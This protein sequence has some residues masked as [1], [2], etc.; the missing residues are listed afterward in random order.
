MIHKSLKSKIDNHKYCNERIIEIRIKTFRG[1]LT[2]IDV[3]ALTEGKEDKS[4]TFYETLQK[5]IKKVPKNDFFILMGDL[6]AQEGNNRL[7][8]YIGK[9]GENNI[10][11]N[12]EKFLDSVSYN[13]LKL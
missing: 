1:L 12:G 5:S 4:I 13:H 7:G 6:N 9:H 8:N 11:K 3:Y 10:N 2:V